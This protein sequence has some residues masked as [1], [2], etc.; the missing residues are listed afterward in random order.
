MVDAEISRYRTLGG[1]AVVS[2][3]LDQHRHPG[4]QAVLGAQKGPTVVEG[5]EELGFV[6]AFTP[7]RTEPGPHLR[8]DMANRGGRL[9]VG[10]REA[11]V[12]EA[13][14]PET[15][16]DLRYLGAQCRHRRHLRGLRRGS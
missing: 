8:R 15:G 12:L 1:I 6:L 11:D 4:A 7:S 14:G 13:E 9:V 3:P 2:L 10:E 5:R 16:G